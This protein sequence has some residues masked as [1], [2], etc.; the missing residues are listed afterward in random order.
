VNPTAIRAIF[1]QIIR[2]FLMG[3]ADVVPGVSGG[4]VALLLGIYERLVGEVRKGA[5]VVSRV[6]RGDKEGTFAAFKSIGWVWLIS[7]LAG[8]GLAIVTLASWLNTQI[9]VRPEIVS[10]VFF[11]LVAA[12]ILVA[13]RSQK[14][15]DSSRLLIMGVA[16]V[17]AFVLLG[18]R[19]GSIENPSWWLIIIAGSIAICAMIL[20]GISGSFILLMFGLYEHV[21]DAI[22]HRE[23]GTVVLFGI[24]A[25]AGLLSFS[26][27]LSWL[28]ENHHGTVLAVLIGIMAGS[29]RVLWPW[30]SGEEGLENVGLGA[31]A[32]GQL[33]GCL[34]AALIAGAVVLIIAEVARR[35]EPSATPVS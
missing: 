2:G 29:L 11:G 33:V 7:L 20:P 32:D 25:L 14:E 17:A 10:A 24:G 21:L 30:P 4:T 6:V 28:L 13:W 15:R 35:G 5:S 31:P 34:V 27:L 18:I 26:T 1:S 16:A 22:E 9:E 19:S 23:L 12:S 8:V 3:A